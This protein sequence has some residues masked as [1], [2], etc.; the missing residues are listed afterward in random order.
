MSAQVP[1]LTVNTRQRLL[2]A[3]INHISALTAKAMIMLE[4][5]REVGDGYTGASLGRSGVVGGFMVRCLPATNIVEISPGIALMAS[6]AV[7]PT[8]DPPEV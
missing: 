3:D 7:S 4:L 5:A 8:Y 2:S 1:R 6:T